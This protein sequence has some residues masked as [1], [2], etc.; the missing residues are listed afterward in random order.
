MRYPTVQ[1][2]IGLSVCVAIGLFLTSI[3]AIPTG[4]AEARES[5]RTLKLYFANTKER[6][7]FT[8]KRNGRYDKAELKRINRFLRDWRRNEPTNMDPQLLDLVWAIY[9]ESGSKAYINVVSAY[10]SPATNKALRSRSRGVAEKSQHMRGKALDWYVTDVPL[11][12]LRA[13]AMRMQGGGV[14]Y[15]PTSGSPFVHTDT[16]NVRAWPRMTR[17]QLVALFPSGETLHLPSDGKPLPGYERAVARRK[18]SGETTLAYLDAG[19]DEG[20]DRAGGNNVAGWLKRVF[21]GGA[22]QAEDNAVDTA[23]APAPAP[24]P[25]PAPAAQPM[26]LPG[27]P[28]PLPATGDPQ[29]LI[30]AAEEAMDARLPKARPQ[31]QSD[32]MLAS[33]STDVAPETAVAPEDTGALASLAFAPAPAPRP[34]PDSGLLAASLE[35]SEGPA[36]LA[37]GEEDAIAALAARSEEPL[38][39]MSNGASDAAFQAPAPAPAPAA[40][41]PAAAGEAPAGPANEGERST[42]LDA[43]N[44]LAASNPANAAAHR[45]VALAFAAA[46]LPLADQPAAPAPAPAAMDREPPAATKGDRIQLAALSMSEPVVEPVQERPIEPV[47]AA[48]VEPAYEA[49]TE[50]LANLISDPVEREFSGFALP[51]P[52]GAPGLFTVPETAAEIAA[53]SATPKLPTLRFQPS[54]PAE[55]AEPAVEESFFSRL[56]ASLAQ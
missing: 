22:D 39:A 44:S 54:Q 52:A 50:E 42:G 46:D 10:R 56:F 6:G 15:Y 13:I 20:G 23:A 25:E 17:K 11:A 48:V 30:A 45:P 28:A 24:A 1:L 7:E 47:A 38:L 41:V 55:P 35:D 43:A 34:R 16:G 40:P 5:N 9:K 8:Y 51:Q 29:M 33:I 21:D 14:G 37:V 3:A 36:A 49:E 4:P 53:Q 2:R 19:S 12:R 31:S 27:E 32:M 18:S 26:P